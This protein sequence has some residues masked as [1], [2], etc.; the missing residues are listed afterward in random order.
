MIKNKNIYFKMVDKVDSKKYIKIGLIVLGVIVTII[1]LYFLFRTKPDY[2]H[3]LNLFVDI[4]K[5]GIPI[6]DPKDPSKEQIIKLDDKTVKDIKQNI[7]NNFGDELNMMFDTY[8]DNDKLSV[9]EMNNLK[10]LDFEILKKSMN[11]RI[12]FYISLNVLISK[13]GVSTCKVDP[14]KFSV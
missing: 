2:D 8:K 12:V 11:S 6:P 14:I 4:Y 1:I 9:K 3:F 5:D 7:S 10:N 13:S